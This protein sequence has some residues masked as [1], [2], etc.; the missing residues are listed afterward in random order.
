MGYNND[1]KDLAKRFDKLQVIFQTP[2]RWWS[3]RDEAF[4]LQK[5]N[6]KSIEKLDVYLTNVLLKCW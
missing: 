1:C 5:S 6:D 2:N 4:N 3:C